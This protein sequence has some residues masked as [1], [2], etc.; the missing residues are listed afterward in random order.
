MAPFS[1]VLA[2]D[3]VV[4]DDDSSKGFPSSGSRR[5]NGIVRA[6]TFGCR[7]WDDGNNVNRCDGICLPGSGLFV[8]RRSCELNLVSG[9]CLHATGSTGDGWKAQP[10]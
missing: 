9:L 4:L 8:G 5:R 1:S 7:V 2:A 6:I 3:E 10:I